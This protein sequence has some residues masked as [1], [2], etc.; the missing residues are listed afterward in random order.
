VSLGAAY[1]KPG[2]W[3]RRSKIIIPSGQSP[4]WIIHHSVS[5]SHQRKTFIIERETEIQIL[6]M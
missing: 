6:K 2:T 1:A 5:K 3:I 4:K